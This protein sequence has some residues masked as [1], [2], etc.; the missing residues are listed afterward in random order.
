VSD[1]LLLDALRMARASG[2]AA[3]IDLAALPL[4]DSFRQLRGDDA[5]ARMFAATAGDDYALLAA[6]SPEF[7]PSTL[8]LPSGATIACIGS[9]E[10]GE[11]QLRLTSEGHPIE[12]PE[13][14][15]FEHQGHHHRDDS[16][17]P[18]ADRP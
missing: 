18:V 17:P 6:L 8:S 13:T 9:L 5:D 15:G 11:P 16:A 10:V 7:D 12:L 2:F 1:G 14:L 4:S 3:T